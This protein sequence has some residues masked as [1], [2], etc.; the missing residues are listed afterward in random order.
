MGVVS[1]CCSNSWIQAIPAPVCLP[2]C[3]DYRGKPPCSASPSCCILT[4]PAVSSPNHASP[5]PHHR[6]GSASHFTKRETEAGGGVSLPKVTGQEEVRVRLA[7][8]IGGVWASCHA[9]SL[10]HPPV[11]GS[12]ASHPGPPLLRT[13]WAPPSRFPGPPQGH[14]PSPPQRPLPGT[15]LG[16]LARPPHPS[17]A[18]E[19]DEVRRMR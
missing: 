9:L 13:P 18:R 16:Q 17:Q 7:F 2:A 1:L 10:P 3:W 15:P 5:H 12:L 6:Q 4:Q 8:W 11:C 19:E 14:S